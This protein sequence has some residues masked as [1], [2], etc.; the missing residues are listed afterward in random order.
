MAVT[1]ERGIAELASDGVR[2]VL[3]DVD[4]TL[5]SQRRLRTFMAIEMARS[6]VTAPAQ[7]PQTARI[8][9]TFRR[10]REQL[11]ELGAVA[12]PLIDLQFARTASALS[13]DESLVRSVIHDWIFAR[14]LPYIRFTG[15][16]G[17]SAVLTALRQQ[18]LRIG[19]LSDYPTDGK[20]DALGVTH[21]FSLRLCT[22]DRA[23]NAFK[24]HPKGF[25]VACEQWGLTPQEVLYVGDRPEI[26][27]A[28]AAAAGTRC[29]I[30]GRSGGWGGAQPGRAASTRH[31]ADIARAALAG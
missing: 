23:I 26:D 7:M 20:L 18:R 1:L 2:A 21:H 12:E 17:V 4:G 5:Y 27:G 16:P 30:V 19:A 9:L 8:I 14:P 24:P 10:V 11:R 22:T 3:F 13:I 25:L 28:G 15:R 31:F 29:V 6:I